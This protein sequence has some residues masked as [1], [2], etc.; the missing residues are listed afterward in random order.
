[1]IIN[2]CEKKENAIA[3]FV[4][5]LHNC[6]LPNLYKLLRI[7]SNSE[8]FSV[9]VL[10][11]I[12]DFF[13]G[14][15]PSLGNNR[16]KAKISFTPNENKEP[17]EHEN[18]SSTLSIS[19]QKQSDERDSTPRL[20]T[21]DLDCTQLLTPLLDDDSDVIFVAISKII[22]NYLITNRTDIREQILNLLQFFGRLVIF[23]LN[24][25]FGFFLKCLKFTFLKLCGRDGNSLISS[26]SIHFSRENSER[27]FRIYRYVS[28]QYVTIKPFERE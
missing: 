12:V 25:I 17:E 22:R 24:D 20:F 26:S 16:M 14:K 15:I 8:E 10:N 9:P 7:P 21:I 2:S 3:L 28:S 27:K 13:C 6:L 23:S 1:V 19:R 11:A 5:A 4:Q 18:E